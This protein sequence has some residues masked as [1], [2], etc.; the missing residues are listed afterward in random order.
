MPGPSPIQTGSRGRRPLVGLTPTE[1]AKAV[2][3]TESRHDE[4][5]HED[6]YQV[7]RAAPCRQPR[8]DPHWL[9]QGGQGAA[10]VRPASVLVTARAPAL[11]RFAGEPQIEALEELGDAV[12]VHFQLVAGAELG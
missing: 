10:C 4:R 1:T 7:A 5:C 8:S 6:E 11:D 12:G 3:L 2:R 9:P